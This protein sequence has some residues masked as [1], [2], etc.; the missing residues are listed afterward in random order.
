VQLAAS[1]ASD[2]VALCDEGAWTG[3][4][5]VVNAIYTS[6]DGGATSVRRVAPENG[7]V[8]SP[9]PQVAIIGGGRLWRTTDDGAT[10]HQVLNA[11]AVVPDSSM[12][13]LGFTTSTQ[14]YV[15]TSRSGMFMTYDAGATWTRVVAP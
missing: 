10:W 12:Q 1:T 5:P 9:S 2:V 15:I 3:P 7:Y 11:G 8:A 13:E 14:G 6:H 4:G